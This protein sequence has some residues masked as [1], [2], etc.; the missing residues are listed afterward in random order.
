MNRPLRL[1]VMMR[2]W[3][4]LYGIM[5]VSWIWRCVP[6]TTRGEPPS[7]PEIHW[8]QMVHATH[9]GKPNKI[10]EMFWTYGWSWTLGTF[11][12]HSFPPMVRGNELQRL[13]M[14]G[15]VDGKRRK[16]RQRLCWVSEILKWTDMDYECCVRTA[17]NRAAWSHG[18]PRPSRPRHK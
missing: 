13:L 3:I 7:Q 16:G 14:D 6:C 18:R 12:G 17:E 15:K 11:G 10:N 9:P 2:E 5:I 1:L 4:G 8:I